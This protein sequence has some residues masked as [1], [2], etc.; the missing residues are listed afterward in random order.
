MSAEHFGE[1]LRASMFGHRMTRG[2]YGY[3]KRTPTQKFTRE[4][5][6]E[7]LW[8]GTA[9]VFRDEDHT[10]HSDVY[11]L[12]QRDQA[13]RNFDL[14]M[15]HFDSLDAEEFEEALQHVLLK[16]RTFKPVESL[17]HWDD[18]EGAYIMVFDDYKQFYIGQST[19][20]RKRIRQH[21]STRKPFDRLIWGTVYNSILPVDEFRALDNTRIYAAR[22]RVPYAVEERAEKAADQMFCLNRMSGGESTPVVRMLSGMIPRNRLHGRVSLPLSYEDYE[23]AQEEIE[24]LVTQADASTRTGLSTQLAGMDMTIYSVQRKSEGQFLWSRRDSIAHAAGLG[25]LSGEDF[26]AFL[27]AMGEQVIWPD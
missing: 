21:W 3:P 17:Q 7:D 8:Q 1:K 2:M 10:E 23:E 27:T 9:W 26:S 5:M 16:G 13:L 22:S 25:K 6:G 4:Q 18:V 24:N 15:Q 19:D 12:V 20:V 11:M 14:S